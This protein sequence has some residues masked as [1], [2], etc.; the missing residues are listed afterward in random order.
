MGWSSS[1]Q[2]F[3]QKVSWA[4][5]VLNGLESCRERYKFQWRVLVYRWMLQH[6][7]SDPWECQVLRIP[8]VT[9]RRGLIFSL[10]FHRWG[11]HWNTG[12]ADGLR[13]GTDLDT[14][15]LVS[16]E[17]QYVLGPKLWYPHQVRMC[18]LLRG[19]FQ[20]SRICL[21]RAG[22]R[23]T[24]IR[25]WMGW[26]LQLGIDH[27]ETAWS[28]SWALLSHAWSEQGLPLLRIDGLRTCAS[29]QASV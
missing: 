16:W 23:R 1:F 4:C 13:H 15:S 22:L 6:S 12:W 9:Y 28:Y 20:C 27:Q 14:I 18:A 3:S 25:L 7:R 29:G 24:L 10:A 2:C 11:G 8:C 17:K 19:T 21:C 26:F 5:K